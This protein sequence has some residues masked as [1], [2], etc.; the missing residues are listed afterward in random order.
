MISTPLGTEEGEWNVSLL[1]FSVSDHQGQVLDAWTPEC[2]HMILTS[3]QILLLE[4]ISHDHE[5]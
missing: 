4:Y 2:P 1:I 5:D 3:R